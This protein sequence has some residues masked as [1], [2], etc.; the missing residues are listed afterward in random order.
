V[1][2]LIVLTMSGVTMSFCDEDVQ[3]RVVITISPSII[4]QA[5]PISLDDDDDVLMATG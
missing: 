1:E 5:G 3:L 2:G 4:D